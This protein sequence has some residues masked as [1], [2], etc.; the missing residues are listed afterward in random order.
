MMRNRN[1]LPGWQLLWAFLICGLFSS[2]HILGILLGIVGTIIVGATLV[3]DRFPGTIINLC[4]NLVHS[5]LSSLNGTDNSYNQEAERLMIRRNAVEAQ[6]RAGYNPDG[7]ALTV[8]DI[9]LLAYTDGKLPKIIRAMAIPTDVDYIRP[10]VVI[11]PNRH[12]PDR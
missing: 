3:E 11:S 12:F 7:P 1:R 4:R 9:G 2:G 5:P 10:F 6:I 8:D